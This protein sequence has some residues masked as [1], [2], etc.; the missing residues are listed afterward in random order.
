MV[1]G[2]QFRQSPLEGSQPAAAQPIRLDGVSV[3]VVDD[4]PDNRL[5]V[6]RFLALA[7]ARADMAEDGI[8]GVEKALSG[9]H[10]IVLM[11]IQM[12]GLDGYEATR[13][14]RGS[15]FSK[16]IIALTA[17]AMKEERNRCLEAG[18][19]DYLTKPIN[20]AAL[21]KCVSDHAHRKDFSQSVS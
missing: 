13:K 4:A 8:D 6:S 5:L 16:P 20:R 9:G 21:L 7:G 10:D 14:L 19:D 15:N 17:H 12:P 11:D 1:L 18:C 2:S 3:L